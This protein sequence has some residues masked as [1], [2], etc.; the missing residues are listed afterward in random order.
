VGREEELHKSLSVALHNL[1]YLAQVSRAGRGVAFP[2]RDYYWNNM[3]NMVVKG[4][5]GCIYSSTRPLAFPA[6]GI[7]DQLCKDDLAQ[8]CKDELAQLCEDHFA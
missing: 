3:G 5:R 7:H 6:G 1:N 2:P 4:E 8:L